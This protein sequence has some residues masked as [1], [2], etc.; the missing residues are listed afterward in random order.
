[1]P[2][3]ILIL[4]LSVLLLIPVAIIIVPKLV[5]KFNAWMDDMTD[6]DYAGTDIKDQ[7]E[8]QSI[9]ADGV[10]ETTRF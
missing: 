8:I 4:V 1:M 10:E 9:D 2:R 5:R 7:K 6:W 3:G